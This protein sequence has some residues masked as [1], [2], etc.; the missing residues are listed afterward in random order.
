MKK[1]IL[2]A[3]IAISGVGIASA[4][5]THVIINTSCGVSVD[6]VYDTVLNDAQDVINDA[7]ILDKYFCGN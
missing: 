3:T 4:E 5:D 1:L 7:I 6:M 2:L